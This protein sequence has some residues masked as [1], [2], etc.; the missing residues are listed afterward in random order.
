MKVENLNPSVW[1]RT[2]LVTDADTGLCALVDPVYDYMESY[3]EELAKRGLNLRYVIAT[4]T[5]A[6]HITA[7]F[8]FAKRDSVDYV[9]WHDTASL[10]VT[11]Y[12]YDEEKIMLGKTP[13]SFHFAPGHT[14]DSMIVQVPGSI[15]TGDFL[16]T[17]KG[18]VGRDD[19]PS[20]RYKVHWDAL[21]VLK[22]F[23]GEDMVLTG[24]DPPECEMQTLG[25][26]RE[27]NPVL[28]MKSYGEYKQWQDEVNAGLG[29]VSKIKVAVPANIFAEIPENIPWLD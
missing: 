29:A 5:H 10:G 24:H 26:N 3:D 22:R 6:D 23:D 21:Q 12:V 9:M 15:M 1:A 11:K 17:G 27:N 8:E 4:H 14:S 2:W 19:L 28:L 7:C 13:I 16:F 18:G 20:G 25:W